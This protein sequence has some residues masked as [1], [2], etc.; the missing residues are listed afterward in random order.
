[1]EN[2]IDQIQKLLEAIDA[3]ISDIELSRATPGVTLIPGGDVNLPST[4]TIGITFKLNGDILLSPEQRRVNSEFD[5]LISNMER[6]E[7]SKSKLG[8]LLSEW[9]GEEWE[10]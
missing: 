7:T 1:M 5:Q 8:E 2:P 4:N 10:Q 6:D 3:A 9:D